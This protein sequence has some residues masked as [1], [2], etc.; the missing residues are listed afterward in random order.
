MILMSAN[1]AARKLIKIVIVKKKI[2]SLSL[3]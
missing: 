2:S 3:F 1:Q